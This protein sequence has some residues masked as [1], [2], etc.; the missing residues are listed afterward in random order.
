METVPIVKIDYGGRIL[1][2]GLRRTDCAGRTGGTHF[3]SSG[4]G[5]GGVRGETEEQR[6]K[7][8]EIA[9]V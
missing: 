1:E 9:I 8:G 7:T 5:A 4:I 6:K 3:P 2:D